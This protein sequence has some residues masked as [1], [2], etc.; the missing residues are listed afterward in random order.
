M[1]S[2][3]GLLGFINSGEPQPLDAGGRPHELLEHSGRGDLIAEALDPA[4]V[5]ESDPPLQGTCPR[6]D[7]GSSGTR[8][9]LPGPTFTREAA[10]CT[11]D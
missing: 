4:L 9:K 7:A 10:G 1:A 6:L 2:N 3:F 8:R 5:V 11:V